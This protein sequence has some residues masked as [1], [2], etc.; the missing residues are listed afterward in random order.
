MLMWLSKQPNILRPNSTAFL[1]IGSQTRTQN[2]GNGLTI[3]DVGINLAG[4]LEAL[5]A[6]SPLSHQ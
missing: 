5:E 6:K 2:S 3:S 1:Q 4:L